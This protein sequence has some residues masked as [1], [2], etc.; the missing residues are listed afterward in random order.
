MRIRRKKWAKPELELC[1]YHVND[2][3]PV[4]GHWN[5]QFI[6]PENPLFLELGC[7]KGRFVSPMALRN[8]DCNYIAI[9]IKSDILGVARRNIQKDFDDAG[10]SV[11]NLLLTAFDINRFNL[12]FSEWDSITGFYINFPNPW[13]KVP[14]KKRRLTYTRQLAQYSKVTVPGGFIKFKTDDYSLY[15]DSLEYF[16]SSDFSISFQTDDLYKDGIPTDTVLTEHEQMYLSLG[17]K[18]C[19]IIAEKKDSL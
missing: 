13:S 14:H 15:K 18:I 11:E 6:H 1:P 9:D 7:G 17:Q 3:F 2:P 5:T 16:K 8:P 4:N 12:V 10:R 19:C